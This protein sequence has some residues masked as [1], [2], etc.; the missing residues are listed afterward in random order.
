M[1]P[2]PAPM[3]IT[4]MVMV[5]SSP[6]ASGPSW[7]TLLPSTDRGSTIIP[8]LEWGCLSTMPVQGWR[9]WLTMPECWHGTGGSWQTLATRGPS[10]KQT[11][12]PDKV[13]PHYIRNL[14]F[15][16][17]CF[18][19]CFQKRIPVLKTYKVIKKGMKIWHKCK[20][21]CNNS[22]ECHYFQHKV[23]VYQLLHIDTVLSQPYKCILMRVVWSP[24]NQ[25]VSG[26]KHCV[27]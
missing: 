2:G 17:L 4:A 24:S 18:S 23:L 19:E 10:A 5:T 9:G 15:A 1:I 21:R 25:F 20:Q 7:P 8:T 13:N 22:V 6:G 3:S 11:F 27:L 26:S 12:L 14:F 16:A